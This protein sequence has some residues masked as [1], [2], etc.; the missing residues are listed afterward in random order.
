MKPI[1]ILHPKPIKPIDYLQE[2]RDKRNISPE[3]EKQ[4]TA[5]FD[6]LFKGDMKNENIFESLEVAKIRT[7]NI[8]KKVERK[9]EI[10]NTNGGYLKNPYLAGEIGDL[11]VESIQAKL[12]I[13]N[14]L[15]GGE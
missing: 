15:N 11:L 12:K 10:M 13:M 3:L 4:K 5:N 9:K 2:M 8:D 14:K 7:N 6:D 1:R